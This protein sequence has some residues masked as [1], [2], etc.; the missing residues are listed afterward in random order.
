MAVDLKASK[1]RMYSTVLD[2]VRKGRMIRTD[3]LDFT[4]DDEAYA[5]VIILHDGEIESYIVNKDGIIL[6][7]LN[8]RYGGEV[9]LRTTR[10]V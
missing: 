9:G 5:D 7:Y 1:P 4:Q 8:E 10:W 2:V 3:S 6:A